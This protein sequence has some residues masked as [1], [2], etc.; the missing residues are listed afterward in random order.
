MEEFILSYDNMS[1]LCNLKA[2]RR[3]LPLPKPY[4]ELWQ[5]VRKV[6]D[7]LHLRNHKN[8]RCHREYSSEPLKEKYPDLNTMVAEQTFVWSSRYKKI[9]NAM[10]MKRFLFYY[11]RMVVHRNNYTAY[12]HKLEKEP[13]LPKVR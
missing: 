1:N 7:R 11:H 8:Q 3:P 5:K 4:D 2:A 6:I 13:T 10:P 9:L 12:C